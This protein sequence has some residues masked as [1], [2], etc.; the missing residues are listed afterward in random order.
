MALALPHQCFV[1]TANPFD[2]SH[3][4]L[5]FRRM[6][7]RPEVSDPPRR[8]RGRG[9]GR[10]R[11]NDLWGFHLA[12]SFLTNRSGGVPGSTPANACTLAGLNPERMPPAST[13][14]PN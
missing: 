4:L 8:F 5:P 7:E 14:A 9:L 11:R 2:V 3:S 1:Q 13:W 6:G 10:F 12:G